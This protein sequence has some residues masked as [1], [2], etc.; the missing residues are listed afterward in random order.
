MKLQQHIKT[1]KALAIA[2]AVLAGGV[3]TATAAPPQ[4]PQTTPSTSQAIKNIAPKGISTALYEC[5]DKPQHNSELLVCVDGERQRQDKRLNAAY[6]ALLRKLGDDK[7][8]QALIKSERSWV[9]F[10]EQ[11]RAFE[12]FI[13]DQDYTSRG[14]DMILNEIFRLCERAN[15][16]ENYL[17]LADN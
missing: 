10:N 14:A 7:A 3:Q 5:V 2:L 11:S 16:L 12:E 17:A 4:T 8:K 6:K 1:A 15:T 13:Y 9:A